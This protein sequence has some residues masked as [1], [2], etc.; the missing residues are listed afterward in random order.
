[1]KK[2]LVGRDRNVTSQ[3]IC[4][5]QC[6][7]MV[8]KSC[9]DQIFCLKLAVEMYLS[10]HRRVHV[11]FVDFEKAYDRVSREGSWEV[12]DIYGMKGHL[13]D[14]VKSLNTGSRACVR[15]DRGLSEWV[16]INVGV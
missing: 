1:M 8:G 6:S 15:S 16:D 5:V 11:T 7:F 4:K 2:V 9:I 13:L 12:L 3:K 14:A 10:V